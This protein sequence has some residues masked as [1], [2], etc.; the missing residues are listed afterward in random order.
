MYLWWQYS[1]RESARLA[2]RFRHPY[3]CGSLGTKG[4]SIRKVTGNFGTKIF[5][6]KTKVLLSQYYFCLLVCLFVLRSGRNI[7]NFFSWFP[8]VEDSF[9]SVVITL[10]VKWPFYLIC[11]TFI[12]S[13]DTADPYPASECISVPIYYNADRD[14]TVTCFNMPC[15]GNQARWTQCG[16]ALFL[17]SQWFVLNPK[18]FGWFRVFIQAL[19]FMTGIA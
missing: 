17:K 10:V 12:S 16:A 19:L 14:R 2:Q 4:T 11:A 13:Q 18:P 1:D 6:G 9:Q 5:Q 8:V 15:S 7:K 3:C